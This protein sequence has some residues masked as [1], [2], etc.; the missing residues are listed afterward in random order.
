MWNE[1]ARI[2]NNSILTGYHV[3]NPNF[4]SLFGGIY[5]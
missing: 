4:S 3:E 5:E 1:M 2:V